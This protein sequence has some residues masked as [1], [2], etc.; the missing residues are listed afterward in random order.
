MTKKS[1]YV[2]QNDDLVKERTSFASFRKNCR[3]MEKALRIKPFSPVQKPVQNVYNFSTKEVYSLFMVNYPH[4]NTS[5]FL[6]INAIYCNSELQQ[7]LQ[8]QP[9]R[10]DN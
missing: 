1:D 3:N 9:S 6:Q 10:H 5:N 2:N 4:R 7:A 8:V